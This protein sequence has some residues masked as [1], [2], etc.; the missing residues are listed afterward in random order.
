MRPNY[1]GETV[2]PRSEALALSSVCLAHP[3]Q[4]RVWCTAGIRAA[5][6]TAV[7]CLCGVPSTPTCLLPSRMGSESTKVVN[8]MH[9][10][11]NILLLGVAAVEL[12]LSSSGGRIYSTSKVICF[13]ETTTDHG[14]HIEGTC[15]AGL[16]TF[17]PFI[18]HDVIHFFHLRSGHAE[19]LEDQRGTLKG[20]P[21]IT[22]RAS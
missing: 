19:S 16:G 10:P 22:S 17:E 2:L 6:E 5:L 9:C 21:R 20:H 7:E 14:G 11:Q 8:S 12:M 15:C 3:P 4:D 1:R 18:S 13:L